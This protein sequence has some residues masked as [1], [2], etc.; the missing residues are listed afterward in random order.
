M[1]FIAFTLLFFMPFL[2]DMGP[3]FSD[4]ADFSCVGAGNPTSS[5]V[6]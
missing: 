1:S 6:G 4:G 5:D 2:L 3:I